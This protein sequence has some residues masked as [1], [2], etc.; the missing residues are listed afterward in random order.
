MR[1]TKSQSLSLHSDINVTPLIDV[2]LVML[3]IF[4]VV[5]PTTQV[6]LDVEIPETSDAETPVNPA[7]ITGQL[8]LVVDE[9]GGLLLNQRE[10]STEGLRSTLS[11]IFEGRRDKTIFLHASPRLS[12]GEVVSVLDIVKGCGALRVGIVESL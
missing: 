7:P 2:M 11:E 1:K 12:Y 3:I 4:M 8:V 10:I 5:S 9:R 6:G